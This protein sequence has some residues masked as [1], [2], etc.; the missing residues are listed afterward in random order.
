M[1]DAS[2]EAPVFGA[3][4]R[5][6]LVFV[7]GV[8]DAAASDDLTLAGVEI[9]RLAQVAGRIGPRVCMARWRPQGQT[10]VARPLAAFNSA[11]ATRWRADPGDGAG[12][13][14]VSLIYIHESETSDA[15]LHHV[16]KVEPGAEPDPAGKR[17]GR[18]PVQRG[19]GG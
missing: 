14:A 16:V 17:P 9:S 19:D 8:F 6:K 4:D 15:I 3:I 11:Y 10:P 1:F 7:D 13:Q 5:L 18:R 2:D 12:G